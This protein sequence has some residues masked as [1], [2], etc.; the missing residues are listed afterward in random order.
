MTITVVTTAQSTELTTLANV[1]LA[2]GITVTTNDTLIEQYI[3]RVSRAITDYVGR[4]FAAQEITETLEGRAS[5][6]LRLK[7]FPA[8][9]I[10]EVKLDGTVVDAADY[11][12]QEPET[13]MIFKE[14]KWDDTF[15]KFDYAVRYQYGYQLPNDGSDLFGE[16]ALPDSIEQA[17]IIMTS[18]MFLSRTRDPSI[19]KEAVPQVYSATYGGSG[20]VATIDTYFT[21]EVQNLLEP[22]R[23]YKV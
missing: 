8:V 9:S 10:V 18:A 2:L 12:L 1:K 16:E 3:D 21:A 20:S 7:K 19:Q 17:A 14:D 5:Q 6:K 4:T 23:A 15:A 13:G 11:A 22:Y